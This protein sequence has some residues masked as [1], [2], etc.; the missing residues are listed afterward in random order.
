M[1]IRKVFVRSA[2]NYDADL[3]SDETGLKCEDPSLAQQHMKEEADINTIV[4]RFGLTGEVPTGM[5]LPTYGDFT[6]IADYQT[7]LHQVK[8]AQESFM[9]LPADV[10]QKFG[11]DPG[12]FVD[13]CSDEKNRE[14][15][16]Q[17]GLIEKPPEPTMS[18]ADVVAAIKENG[19]GGSGTGARVGGEPAQGSGKG[20][21]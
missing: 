15:L 6:G 18:L 7:A 20:P 1:T 16:V 3:V 11:N 21:A 8:A 9:S 17:M 5:R 19:N 12:A 13:F 2:Y 14:A 10:R 4:K